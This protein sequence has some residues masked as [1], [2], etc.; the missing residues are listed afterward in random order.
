MADTQNNAKNVIKSNINRKE[1]SCIIKLN[2]PP[3]Y[4]DS[5]VAIKPL[6]WIIIAI[7]KNY[8]PKMKLNQSIEIL[9]LPSLR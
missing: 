3:T 1:K 4:S 2:L 6:S 8:R 9:N 5:G 7:E